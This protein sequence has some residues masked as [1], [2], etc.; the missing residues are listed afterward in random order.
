MINFE[1]LLLISLC[2]LLFRLFGLN[3]LLLIFIFRRILE[4]EE[5]IYPVTLVLW[6]EDI[7]LTIVD[8]MR[9]S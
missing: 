5:Q 9:I 1:I 7:L 3:P 6:Q 8:E 4:F 2:I